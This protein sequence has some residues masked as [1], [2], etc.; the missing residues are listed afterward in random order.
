MAGRQESVR[1]P[2]VRGE[3]RTLGLKF[4]YR[5]GIARAEGKGQDQC[6]KLCIAVALSLGIPPFKG[7]D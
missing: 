6:N 4:Y 7:S 2:A 1:D 3:V 5:Q